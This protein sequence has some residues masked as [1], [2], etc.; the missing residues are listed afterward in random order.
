MLALIVALP[1][2]FVNL[3]V[4]SRFGIAVTD[5]QAMKIAGTEALWNTQQPASF[6]V[7][8]IGGFTKDD[9]NPSVD[10]EIPK[11]LSFLAT[12]DINGKVQGINQLQSQESSKYG[13]SNYV[14][15]IRTLYIAMRVMA[16]LGTL[17]F[18]LA[19]V[20]A[21]LYRRR[22]L[23]TARWFLWSA[24][25]TTVFPFLAAAAG[26]VLT[27]MGRQPWIVQNLLRDDKSNSPNVSS[28]TIG[29]SIAVF[30][31]L[32][33]G[34]GAT[35]FVLMR[36]YARIDPPGSDGDDAPGRLAVGY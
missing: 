30:A 3:T 22:K 23:E 10:I 1:V 32:Y 6:S 17:M 19:A 14:P 27:E 12:G 13:N 2:T 18:L 5:A 34:L 15:S 36:R 16:Y 25:V 20:G 4:G 7:F 9:Q 35:D 29:T 31:T 21:F 33:I 24:V 11:L 8:Q 28:A 26:W